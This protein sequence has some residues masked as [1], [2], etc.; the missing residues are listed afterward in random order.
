MNCSNTGIGIRG[1]SIIFGSRGNRVL[2]YRGNTNISFSRRGT[3][4]VLLRG[5]VRVLIG[6]GDNDCGSAT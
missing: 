2:I 4:R 3:G 5:R 1:V 6:L